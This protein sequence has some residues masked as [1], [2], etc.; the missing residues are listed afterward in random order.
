RNET[1]SGDSLIVHPHI[2]SQIRTAEAGRFAEAFKRP[3]PNPI[4]P[5]AVERFE[6]PQ[7]SQELQG[8]ITVSNFTFKFERGY[9]ERFYHERDAFILKNNLLLMG[10]VAQ[11]M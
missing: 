4:P 7:T 2:A 11:L 8:S 1:N 6:L 5:Q 9:L 10:G 3:I